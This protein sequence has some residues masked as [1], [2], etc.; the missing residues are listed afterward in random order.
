[1]EKTLNYALNEALEMGRLSAMP[2]FLEKELREKI[3]QEIEKK[4]Q[5]YLELAKDKDSEDH[6]VYLGVSNGM[7]F[8]QI[9]V[10]FPRDN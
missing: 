10:E 6:Q 5:P 2:S 9:I 4:R 8:A 7:Y 3:A 1:L